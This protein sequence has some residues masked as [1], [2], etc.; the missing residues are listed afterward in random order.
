MFGRAAWPPGPRRWMLEL[1]ASRG[2]QRWA[3]GFPATRGLARREGEALMGLVSGF[4]GS[5]A[6]LALVEL[7]VLDRLRDRP[8]TAA[9]LAPVLGLAADRAAILLQAGVALRLLRRGRGGRY[10]LARRGAALLGVPGLGAMIRHHH[11]LY[12]D[13]TDPVALLRS[14]VDT[15]LARFWPYVF[16]A[17]GPVAPEVAATYS[18]LMAESQELVAEETL[19]AVSLAEVGCLMDVGG[20]TGAFLSAVGRRWTGPR[21]MLFD[22]PEVVAGATARFARHGLAARAEIRPGSFRTDP[23]PRGADAISMVRVLYD[24]ADSTVAALLSQAHAALPPG[25][26]LLISEPMS[27]GARPTM[28]GD[29][30]FAFY[31]LAMRTGRCRSAEEIAQLCTDAGFSG[32]R[33]IPTVRPFLTSVVLATR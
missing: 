7:G 24:H 33:A 19:R 2:F 31:T 10:A 17:A 4:V 22:L 30:Y 13:L 8:R 14:E 26:R 1:V 29:V 9:E 20:G 3:A 6:L 11:V 23:L 25:G 32:V 15:E 12:R 16:G 28:A 27:G 21:L 18:D 5:Q